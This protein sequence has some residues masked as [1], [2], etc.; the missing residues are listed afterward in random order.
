MPAP[1]PTPASTCALIDRGRRI[2]GRMASRGGAPER[3]RRHRRVRTSP[4]GTPGSRRSSTDWV[5]RGLARPWTDTFHVATPEGLQGTR[6][7]PM[8]Y[9]ATA[10]L[11][12]LVED[13]AGRLALEYPTEVG[14]GRA[15]P[16]DRRVAWSTATRPRRGA[17]HARPAGARPAAGPPRRE[18]AAADRT[19]EPALALVAH[20]P[21]RAWPALDGAFVNESP[22]LTFVADDGRRRG[23]GAPVL[24]AHSDPVLAAAH[25]D[26]PLGA[27]P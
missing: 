13:L 23:D 7:G 22:V 21:A 25:L 24:V 8:R 18:R 11:R 16:G 5:E 20:W 9:A 26:D 10:G 3:P 17:V 15:R 6:T 12:S 14:R 2:G 27:G 1:W 19:W 4:R